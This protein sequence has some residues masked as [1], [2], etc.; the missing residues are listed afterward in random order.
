MG[1]SKTAKKA[2]LG[3]SVEMEGH[4]LLLKVAQLSFVDG[5][6]NNQIAVLLH[7]DRLLASPTNTRL[8]QK[9]INKAAQWLLEEHERRQAE[10]NAAL[11]PDLGDALKAKYGHLLE[12]RVLR[13]SPI[14]TNSDYARLRRR[15]AKATADYFDE[16]A[17]TAEQQGEELHVGV[18]GGQTVLEVVTSL[19]ERTRP[20]LYFYPSAIIGRG[21]IIDLSSVGPETNATIAWGRNGWIQNRL[22]YGTVTPYEIG[23][24]EKLDLNGIR[25]QIAENIE[26]FLSIAAIKKVLLSMA[27][28]NVAIAGLGPLRPADDAPESTIVPTLYALSVLHRLGIEAQI[29]A[30][31]GVIGSLSYCLFDENGKGDEKWNFFLTA[32]YPKGLELYRDLVEDKR[33]VIVTGGP[34]KE[35]VIKTALDARLF[36]VLITDAVTAKRLMED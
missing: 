4:D 9:L 24:R 11:L 17:E 12:A 3:R 30:Q 35:Q 8:V 34:Y 16:L 15:M 25:R 13:S 2:D 19:P 6:K 18:G 10:D 29:L 23:S 36:N 21:G 33:P 1:K 20:H 28:I 5:K 26:S 22:H 14:Q 7:K 32:G 27:N 31:E